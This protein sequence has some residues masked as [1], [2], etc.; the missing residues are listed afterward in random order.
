M[1]ISAIITITTFT[2]AFTLALALA[3]TFLSVLGYITCL[4]ILA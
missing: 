4:Y 3:I 2:L 1:L